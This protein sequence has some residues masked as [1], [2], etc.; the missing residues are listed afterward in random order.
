M[1]IE[2]QNNPKQPNGMPKLQ[3]CKKALQKATKIE[4]IDF[5]ASQWDADLGLRFLD[6]RFKFLVVG[7]KVLD[8]GMGKG[9]E[10]CAKAVDN[11]LLNAKSLKMDCRASLAMTGRGKR[12]M[13]CRVT[14]LLAMTGVEVRTPSVLKAPPASLARV[15]YAFWRFFFIFESYFVLALKGI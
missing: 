12:K 10:A 15:R 7:F 8:R 6:L 9:C 3:K 4:K 2:T 13:D 1:Q 11:F 5:L 14:L